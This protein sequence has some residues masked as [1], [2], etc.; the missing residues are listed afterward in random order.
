MDGEMIVKCLVSNMLCLNKES[1]GFVIK[2]NATVQLRFNLGYLFL[3][4]NTNF[5]WD[6][7]S[8]EMVN[9][10]TVW[11]FKTVVL[12]MKEIFAKSQLCVK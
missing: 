8:K 10:S 1:I 2:L 4:G 5:I 7:M 6:G 11:T 12:R 3:L 9:F